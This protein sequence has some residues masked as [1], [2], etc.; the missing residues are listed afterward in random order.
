MINVNRLLITKLKSV[1]IFLDPEQNKTIVAAFLVPVFL[2]YLHKNVCFGR[3]FV[4]RL[5][6]FFVVCSE[7]RAILPKKKR[8]F[9]C[10]FFFLLNGYYLKIN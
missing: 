3:F 8:N 2:L 4:G 7:K 6:R 9:C 5:G 1:E 10:W